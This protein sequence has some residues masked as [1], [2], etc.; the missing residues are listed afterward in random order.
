LEEISWNH[1]NPQSHCI[2]C[3]P[4]HPV[5]WL[6]LVLI[7]CELCW[8]YLDMDFG[9][10]SAATQSDFSYQNRWEFGTKYDQIHSN[11]LYAYGWC[12]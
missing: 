6:H 3:H 1:W 2:Q 12:K 9:L 4:D 7:E 10:Q 11:M 8:I 5:T